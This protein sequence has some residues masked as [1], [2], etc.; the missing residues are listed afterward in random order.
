MLLTSYF[1]QPINHT[2]ACFDLYYLKINTRLC[3]DYMLFSSLIVKRWRL[4]KLFIEDEIHL[5]TKN[6]QATQ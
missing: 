3:H 2:Q 1:K 5:G 6:Q 4:A